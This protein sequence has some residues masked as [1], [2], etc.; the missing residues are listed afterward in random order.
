MEL[1]KGQ[2]N[3]NLLMEVGIKENLLQM[4]LKEKGFISGQMEENMKDNEKKIKCMEKEKLY[5]QA[6][7]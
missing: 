2:E 5:G 7:Y 1:K 4:K 3:Q 6:L